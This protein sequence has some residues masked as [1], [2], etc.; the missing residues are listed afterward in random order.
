MEN[1]NIILASKSPRRKELLGNIVPN[2]I[3]KTKDVEEIYPNTLAAK[4]VAA[5][6]AKLKADAFK[7]DLKPNDIVITSDTTVVLGKTIYGKPKDRQDAIEIIQALSGKM[8]EV[9]T[10]VCLKNIYKE[11]V[12]SCTTKV[13]FK[14]LSLEEIEYYVDT[15][16]PFDKAGAYAIQEWIGFIG[17][18]KIEGDYNNIVGLP[19]QALHT[20][21]TQFCNSL[22]KA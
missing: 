9:I 1:F 20:K 12:F 7:E 6:L 4:E 10:G 18:E 5:Y 21:L 14:T 13:F 15:F 8:H 3:L 19:L 2:F 17:I 11:E 16:K 22:L